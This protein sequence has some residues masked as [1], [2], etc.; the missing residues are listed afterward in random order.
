MTGP[1]NRG[2]ITIDQLSIRPADAAQW[3][4]MVSHDYRAARKYD[5]PLGAAREVRDSWARVVALSWVQDG[6]VNDYSTFGYLVACDWYAAALRLHH[7]RT[8]HASTRATA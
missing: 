2:P 3:R 7:R 8:D 4:R 5:S 6:H 1:T